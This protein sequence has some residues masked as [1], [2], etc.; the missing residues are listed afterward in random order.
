MEGCVS[1]RY[2][3]CGYG[4]RGATA[5]LAPLLLQASVSITS[6]TYLTLQSPLLYDTR[7]CLRVRLF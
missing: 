2:S 7:T 4:S 5:G 6:V 3:R 1:E